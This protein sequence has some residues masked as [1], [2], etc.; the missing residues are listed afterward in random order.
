MNADGTVD[1]DVRKAACASAVT[2]DLPMGYTEVASRPTSDQLPPTLAEFGKDL[3]ALAKNGKIKIVYGMAQKLADG[4]VPP[5][6]KGKRVISVDVGGL[7]AGASYKGQFE[8]RV[9]DILQEA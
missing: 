5:A 2:S 4:N 7:V 9:K 6:L 8:E 1:L 3:V